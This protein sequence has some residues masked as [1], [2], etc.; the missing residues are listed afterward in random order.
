MAWAHR[1]ARPWHYRLPT[2]HDLE[3]LAV[4]W[5]RDP[6]AALSHD[7]ALAAYELRDINL[8]K[9]RVTVPLGRR[10]RKAGGEGYV[11]QHQHLGPSR[12]HSGRAYA[13]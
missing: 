10:I 3:A 7:S 9:Y 12:L 4:L 5:T 8:S 1:T 11:I 2:G 6:A 13:P